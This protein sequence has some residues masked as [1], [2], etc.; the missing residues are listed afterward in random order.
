MWPNVLFVGWQIAL[1]LVR[2]GEE[3]DATVASSQSSESKKD[4]VDF[5]ESSSNTIQKENSKLEESSNPEQM[6]ES[7]TCEEVDKVQAVPDNQ[8]TDTEVI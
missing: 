6:G 1:Q 8:S 4:K 2:K 7:E 3:I 5:D